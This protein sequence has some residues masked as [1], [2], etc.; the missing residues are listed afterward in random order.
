M[1][2]RTPIGARIC[3]FLLDGMV[4]LYEE[5]E[6][7][8]GGRAFD[9]G[10]HIFTR[11]LEVG[12]VPDLYQRLSIPGEVVT[13]HQTTL[14]KI[15]DSYLQSSPTESPSASPRISKIHTKL[16]PMLAD[17]FSSLSAYAQSAIRRALRPSPS[18]V[19][20]P[21]SS[22][23]NISPVSPPAELDVMLPKVC[24]TFV[25]VTQCIVSILLATH[26]T[27]LTSTEIPTDVDVFYK[28]HYNGGA[29]FVE[30]IIGE[31]HARSAVRNYRATDTC[32]DQ[33]ILRLLDKFLP[34]I[35]FGKPIEPT[36]ATASASAPT[37]AQPSPSTAAGSAGFS[38]LKRDL[39]R[40]LGILSHENKAVQDRVRN[41]GGIEVVMNLCVIDERNP[42]LREHAIF[43]LHNLLKDNP[44]NQAVVDEIKPMGRWGDDGVLK[45]MPGATRR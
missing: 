21:T 17:C 14:L 22:V 20:S 18:E 10:Y 6:S 39:V 41:C 44:A 12:L 25:L 42:Y 23:M 32:L 24:E 19:E 16:V 38:Y 3:V 7:S 31:Y 13:P 37:E 29:G 1:L 9:A 15:V 43:T 34:R 36:T 26:G 4:K 30:N 35:N 28:D 8:E 27:D 33:E 2:T 11:I 40:L 5:D 45:D